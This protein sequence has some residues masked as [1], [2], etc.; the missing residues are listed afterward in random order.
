MS[1]QNDARPDVLSNDASSLVPLIVHQLVDGF[2]SV[3]RTALETGLEGGVGMPQEARQA[4]S[5]HGGDADIQGGGTQNERGP[6]TGKKAVDEKQA[7]R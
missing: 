2:A 1:P 6:T 3:Y 4:W 5:F 7:H